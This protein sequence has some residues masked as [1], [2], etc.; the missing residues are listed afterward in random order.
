MLLNSGVSSLRFFL[1]IHHRRTTRYFEPY[2]HRRRRRRNFVK[3]PQRITLDRNLRIKGVCRVSGN[4]IVKYYFAYPPTIVY[5]L[6]GR[7][8]RTIRQKRVSRLCRYRR[9]KI[10]TTSHFVDLIVRS[11]C[12]VFRPNGPERR[13]TIATSPLFSNPLTRRWQAQDKV[14]VG[15]YSY[16]ITHPN[17]LHTTIHRLAG[18][19]HLDFLFVRPVPLMGLRDLELYEP[20][21]GRHIMNKA[22][23]LFVIFHT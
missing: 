7:N 17:V 10:T 12:E 22:A 9:I 13:F 19:R 2:A 14:A 18:L 23:F 1:F 20:L 11:C 8:F 4:W 6:L 16:N 3:S 21:L 5:M 15:Y